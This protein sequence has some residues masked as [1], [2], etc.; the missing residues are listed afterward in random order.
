M[1]R[2][3]LAV[4]LVASIA[5]PAL[6]QDAV[7]RGKQAFTDSKCLVCHFVGGAGNKNGPVL[8][9]VGAKLSAEEIRQWIVDAPAM[10]AKAKITR[11]PPMKA[12]T[13]LPKD[14]VDALVAYLSTLKK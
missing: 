9:D 13:D 14:T 11:K 3:A 1:S 5:A 2:I 12:Y 10:A 4:F 6:A 8:D 7:A